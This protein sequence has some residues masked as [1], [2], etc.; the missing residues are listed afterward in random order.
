MNRKG[1]TISFLVQA[2]SLN[3]DE[4]YG[5]VSILKKIHRGNGYTYIFASR[6]SLR[7]SIVKYA[8][9][10]LGWK[11]A[12]I[13]STDVAQI[14]IEK[15]KKDNYFYEEADLFGYMWTKGKGGAALPRTGVVKLTHLISLEPFFGDQELLSNKNFA[16]RAGK[17]PNLANVETSLSIFKYSLSID[18]DRV[19]V[20]E[21]LGFNLQPEEKIRRVNTLLEAVKNLYRD[22]RNRREDLKPILAIGGVYP[23]KALFFH[24]ALNI[25]WSGSKPNLKIEPLEEVLNSEFEYFDGD[26][27]VKSKVS[28]FTLKGVRKGIFGNLDNKEDWILSPEQVIDKIKKI[29]EKVY[30]EN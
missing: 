4:G 9:E 22:I 15:M 8:V 19:G 14:D 10:N 11:Y 26:K 28:D 23:V 7:Y 13:S 17:D 1:L 3:Y 12:P 16:D 18:L 29:V 24:N 20:D 21:N 5:N 25:Y 6:Q 27:M 30:F 2:N